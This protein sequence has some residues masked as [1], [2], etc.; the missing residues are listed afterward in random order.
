M[1]ADLTGFGVEP[2]ENSNTGPAGG[3]EI[4]TG[5]ASGNTALDQTG[6]SFDDSRVQALEAQVLAQPEIRQAKVEVLQQAIRKGEYS[7]SSDQVAD[8]MARELSGET[9]G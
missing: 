3:S 4:G 6:F 1:K 5:S 2:P 7:V 8:A 9:K